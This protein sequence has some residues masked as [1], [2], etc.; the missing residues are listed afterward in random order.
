MKKFKV[1]LE[2]SVPD[3]LG[4]YETD[5]MTVA[6][7]VKEKLCEPPFPVEV[8]DVDAREVHVEEETEP[9]GP[10]I[11]EGDILISSIAEEKYAID[12]ELRVVGFDEE[13]E[14]LIVV[15]T[16][17]R[18]EIKLHRDEVDSIIRG[19]ET[20]AYKEATMKKEQIKRA[21]KLFRHRQEGAKT[22]AD[23]TK[24]SPASMYFAG[25]AKAYAFCADYLEANSGLAIGG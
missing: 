13:D 8:S 3:A 18:E 5:E 16:K 1:I 10:T 4:G 19:D 24:K 9:E 20:F 15:M 22:E 21:V 14:N 7:V 17:D 23:L 6:N 11:E 12:G 25:Q 2:V